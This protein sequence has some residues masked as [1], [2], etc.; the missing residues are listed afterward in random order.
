MKLKEKANKRIFLK[1][2]YDGRCL[3]CGER[4]HAGKSA[5]WDPTS[6]RRL[7]HF[8]ILGPPRF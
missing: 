7:H 2:Q 4:V 1:L 8:R 6:R 3:N 5:Y